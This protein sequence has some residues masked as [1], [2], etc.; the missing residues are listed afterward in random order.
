MR[1]TS[2]VDL[3]DVDRELVEKL[4]SYNDVLLLPSDASYE[5]IRQRL[6]AL[7]KFGILNLS[8]NPLDYDIAALKAQCAN[9]QSKKRSLTAQLRESRKRYKKASEQSKEHYEGKTRAE[10][11]A[12]RVRE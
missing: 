3:D 1:V 5:K 6:L 9:L 2:E 11:E 12:V 8:L 10:A 4:R 7:H